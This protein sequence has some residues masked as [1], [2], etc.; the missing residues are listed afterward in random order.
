MAPLVCTCGPEIPPQI[1]SDSDRLT[2]IENEDPIPIPGPVTV[3][4]CAVHS[5]PHDISPE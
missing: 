4:Q 3:G 1:V 5:S 2:L